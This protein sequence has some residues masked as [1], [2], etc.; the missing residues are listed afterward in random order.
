MM[1]IG[2]TKSIVRKT[3]SSLLFVSYLLFGCPHAA[4]A[5]TLAAQQYQ[6][7]INVAQLP[8]TIANAISP[9]LTDLLNYL[10]QITGQTFSQGT[11]ASSGIVLLTTSASG[12]PSGAAAALAGTVPGT[13]FI[14]GD[15]THLVIVANEA[16]GF[17]NGISFYLES[18]GV[19]WLL[20]GN[21]W[22]IVPNLSNI[23]LTVNQ[24]VTPAFRMR[25]FAGTGGFLSSHWG[26]NYA[27]SSLNAN[28]WTQWKRR[29]RTGGIWGLAVQNPGY[30]TKPN[31]ADPG[32]VNSY[33]ATAINRSVAQNGAPPAGST[34]SVEPSD[35]GGW[36]PST[37]SGLPGN[38]SPGD[39]DWYLVNQCAKMLAANYP[40]VYAAAMAYYD[41]ASLPSF[42]LESNIVVMEAPYAYQPV[43]PTELITQWKSTANPKTMYDFWGIPE[44]FGD[45]PVFDFLALGAKLRYWQTQGIL[46]ISAETTYGGGAMGLG[47]Y[48][49]AELMWNIGLDEVALRND[50]YTQ[51]FG[52]AKV[53]MQRMLERWSK[54]FELISVEIANSFEDISEAEQL[55][56]GNPSVISRI[57]DFATYVHY[58]RLYI[59]LMNESDTTKQITRATGLIQHVLS[60]ND[61][62]MIDT[63]R[64]ADLFSA[65][66]P[67]LVAAFSLV[68]A[69][70][71]AW[72]GVKTLSHS[73]IM[74]LIADGKLNY[75][76]PNWTE[77]NFT[78]AMTT[79]PINVNVPVQS[80]VWETP[81]VTIIDADVFFDVKAGMT[82]IPLRVS[83]MVDLWITVSN[84]AGQII[85][86]QLITNA[87]PSGASNVWPYISTEQQLNIPA[88][89]GIYKVRFEPTGDSSHKGFLAFRTW[90]GVPTA[91]TSILPFAPGT[92]NGVSYGPQRLYFY[93][94]KGLTTLAM[95]IPGNAWLG[96]C[97]TC[98]STFALLDADGRSV[99]AQYQD[100]YQV[101]TAAVPS[102][103]DGRI[104]SM[105]F[106]F[107]L[108]NP[109]M[110]LNAPTSFSLSPQTLMAPGDA[111]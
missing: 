89:P 63:I 24:L 88:S 66:Y 96:S 13:F 26:T 17:S 76:L 3:S 109:V 104:W 42:P 68:P 91:M 21:N 46:G 58:L 55:A 83:R 33:C 87:V 51:A 54:S 77:K 23:T 64:I 16:T 38:G 8:P 1:V 60:I 2:E 100:Q 29:L 108:S 31:V 47:L 56:V 78:G 50:W 105:N 45:K 52:P 40:G 53:P 14:Q 48:E 73:D 84:A 80:G 106:P 98:S 69:P 35:G 44:W 9:A 103:E 81:I 94:P 107:L 30:N 4:S 6:N 12:L 61:S 99:S 85:F 43:P 72:A 19:R 59:E 34:V 82:G 110:M 5:A 15:A 70:G 22:T 41:H 75:S 93:V 28:L 57:D 74:A 95:Y 20:P 90:K 67:S 27:P 10:A 79:L 65:R 92:I 36:A 7:N 32:V 49:A 111:L 97:H 18:L 37:T 62:Q 39:Q 101:L 86:Q 102:G 11:S 71:P 25:D